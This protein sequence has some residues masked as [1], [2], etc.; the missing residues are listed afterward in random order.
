MSKAEIIKEK[1]RLLF[2]SLDLNWYGY[3]ALKQLETE[4]L[5]KL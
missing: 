1:Y 4:E 5:N 3:L 2:L